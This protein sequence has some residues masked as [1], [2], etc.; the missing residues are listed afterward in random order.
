M[1]NLQRS[2]FQSANDALYGSAISDVRR[3]QEPLL[4]A[5]TES[6]IQEEV[7]TDLGVTR[8]MNDVAEE[9]LGRRQRA[10]GFRLSDRQ[11]AGQ[12]K[13]L[14]LAQSTAEA[15]TATRTRDSAQDRARISNLASAGLSDYLTDVELGG[16]NTAAELENQRN[17][18]K[19]QDKA[20][21]FAS[22]LGAAGTVVGAGVGFAI[23]GGNPYGAALGAGMVS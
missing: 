11:L 10:L 3:L 9:V 20:Q 4:R 6:A 17:I 7:D 8:S 12:K 14:A 21:G 22:A 19:Q 18:A 5:G 13:Q 23:T 1:A 15:A 2:A 16:L